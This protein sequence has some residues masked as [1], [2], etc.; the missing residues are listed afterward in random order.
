MFPDQKEKVACCINFGARRR[1][2]ADGGRRQRKFTYPPSTLTITLTR[3]VET[4]PP[5]L[6]RLAGDSSSIGEREGIAFNLSAPQR[7][8]MAG[9]ELELLHLPDEILLLILQYV[10]QQDL[11]AC[12]VACHRLARLGLHRAVWRHR[13]AMGFEERKGLYNGESQYHFNCVCPVLRLAPSVR[14]LALRIPE[15][16]PSPRLYTSTACGATKLAVALSAAGG[17]SLLEAVAVVRH[18]EAL[19][20]LRH[21]VLHFTAQAKNGDADAA[22]SELLESAALTRGLEQLEVRG[23]VPVDITVRARPP[24][25]PAHSPSLKV[26]IADFA[27]SNKS[28]S[29]IDYVLSV[30]RDTLHEVLLYGCP[31]VTA[32]SVASLPK[33]H[34]LSVDAFSGMAPL[35][36]C[37]RLRTLSLTLWYGGMQAV[38]EAA[39]LLKSLHKLNKCD[40]TTWGGADTAMVLINGLAASGCSQVTRL[41]VATQPGSGPELCGRGRLEPLLSALAALPALRRLYLDRV[42]A[43]SACSEFFRAL[44]T[45]APALQCVGVLLS[46]TVSAG[47][48]LCPH[49]W[50]H[51]SAVKDAMRANPGLHVQVET[52]L[53]AAGGPCRKWNRK[54]PCH[55]EEVASWRQGE[56][57]SKI[58]S[59]GIF[60]HC[61]SDK[62]NCARFNMPGL[63]TV[64]WCKI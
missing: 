10:G 33:L 58:V 23:F 11:L 34:T 32:A 26:L 19:G 31:A 62:C 46:G 5:T 43:F 8:T 44:E 38:P 27:Y 15:E 49:A 24:G 37:E 50:L 55:A 14:T 59:L 18:Q 36:A 63:G 16:R 1:K 61:Q 28:A 54:V 45:A 3:L 22:T 56:S 9:V 47:G 6:A 60:A 2:D 53:H 42:L 20:R 4:E 17:P 25:T 21:L 48:N 7:Y 64:K 13:R 30:H 35:S 41:H 57:K 39:D 29:F 52:Q 40:L 12:R 51:N